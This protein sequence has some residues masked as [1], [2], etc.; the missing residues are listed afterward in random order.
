[1]SGFSYPSSNKQNGFTAVE[2]LIT[3]FVASLFLASGYVLY[4]AVLNR[5]SQTRQRAEADNV[6]MDYIRR[7]E[8]PVTATCSPSTPLTNQPL[9][10][11]EG[12]ANVRISVQVSCPLSSVPR[13]SQITA[14]V[15][16]GEGSGATYVRHSMYVSQ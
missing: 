11:I 15:N 6:A 12:L 16:Y 5:S 13:V 2:L 14:T 10:G 1:M 8:A 4:D 9:T 7:Y 3:L